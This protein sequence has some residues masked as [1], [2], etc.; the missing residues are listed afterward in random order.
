[1]DNSSSVF[2]VIPP[3]VSFRVT[4]KEM[5]IYC[6]KLNFA[7]RQ[8]ENIIV[9]IYN[10]VSFTSFITSLAWTVS[11][12]EQRLLFIRLC[13]GCVRCC[14]PNRFCYT[15]KD[16]RALRCGV[17]PY[18]HGEVKWEW[19][20]CDFSTCFSQEPSAK[21]LTLSLTASSQWWEGTGFFCRT[22]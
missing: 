14:H 16:F 21:M 12:S 20:G 19:G 7:Q 11:F 5:P 8:Y 6:D 17:T 2:S 4:C 3:W 10:L 15:D 22:G 18:L 9:L 13:R 1:M